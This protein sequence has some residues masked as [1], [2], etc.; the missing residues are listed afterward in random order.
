MWKTGPNPLIW[1][2]SIRHYNPNEALQLRFM[3]LDHNPREVFSPSR[4]STSYQTWGFTMGLERFKVIQLGYTAKSV[5]LVA[6]NRELR[7]TIQSTSDVGPSFC[8]SWYDLL[9]GFISWWIWSWELHRSVFC[10]QLQIHHKKWT[11]HPAHK[12]NFAAASFETSNL[13]DTS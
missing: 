9:D 12:N 5:H 11:S 2:S 4:D 1:P 6:C 3:D 8:F 7:T 13:R 10:F